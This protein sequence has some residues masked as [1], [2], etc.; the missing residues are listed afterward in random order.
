MKLGKS[1]VQLAQELERQ[2][3]AKRDFTADTRHLQMLPSGELQIEG[4]SVEV[5]PTTQHAQRQIAQRVNIPTRYFTR[6]R[7][8]APE[9]M[10]HNVNHWFHS[11]HEQ[12][13]VRTLD[14]KARAFLSNR[15][16]RLDHYELA[17]AVLPVLGHMGEGIKVASCEVTEQRLYLKVINERLQLDVKVGDPVQAG[18]A[19]SNSE[20]GMGSLTVEPLVYRLVCRNG[21]IAKDYGTRKH[22]VGRAATED[23][24]YELFSDETLKAD[25]RAFYLKVQDTV[26]AAVKMST[27]SR[28]VEQMRAASD[29]K[30][31][32]HPAKAVELTAKAYSLTQGES[33]GVLSHLIQGGDLSAYGLLNAIT[34]TS[35][36]VEDYDRATELEHI[37]CDLLTIPAQKWK[38]LATAD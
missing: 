12:R 22:H 19:I 23:A 15:Y 17:E 31:E 29:R 1:L 32:G 4:E 11:H 7:D 38:A 14:G 2:A 8:E 5:F 33:G 25:D 35:Q 10:A 18:I 24:T 9:L 34:R 6:M 26:R 37:G 28:I 27:F 21:A 16:R 13:M 36:D 3:R 20:I 30:I